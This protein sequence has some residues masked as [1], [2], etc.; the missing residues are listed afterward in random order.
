LLLVF[1]AY[2]GWFYNDLRGADC[3]C[4]PLIKRAVGPGFF[5]TDGLMLVLAALAGLW[6]KP[7]H[8][9]RTAGIV[10]GS[11]VVFALASFG[12]N[13]V[14]QSGTKAPDMITV[15]GKPASLQLGKIF[16]F[17][18]DPEC[19]HCE[20]AAKRMA[21]HNWKDTKL[22]AI[23]TRVPQF[24]QDFLNATKL[25]AGIS[26]NLDLLKPIFPFG[27]PPFGVAVENGHQKAALQIF[28]EQEP[29]KTL[30]TLEFI[31]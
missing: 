25:K 5:I 3:S 22:I 12:M 13:V 7:S 16:L 23:P 28:D 26:P 27:D 19:M 6:A 8:G 4:F 29:Q 11:V 20:D 9:L 15:D 14:R 17:F 2:V 21:K 30:R 18:F 1:M 24:A 31:E 10:L